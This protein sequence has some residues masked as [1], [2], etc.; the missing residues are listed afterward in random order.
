MSSDKISIEQENPQIV[1]SD[2]NQKIPRVPSTNSVRKSLDSRAS[3]ES[4]DISKSSRINSNHVVASGLEEPQPIKASNS[5]SQNSLLKNLSTNI[6]SSMSVKKSFSA[7]SL[8]AVEPSNINSVKDLSSCNDNSPLA[9]S[10]QIEISPRPKIDQAFLPSSLSM[11]QEKNPVEI[12]NKSQELKPSSYSNLVNLKSDL[13]NTTITASNITEAGKLNN[14]QGANTDASR[15]SDLEKA[16]EEP[17]KLNIKEMQK[18]LHESQSST[19]VDKIKIESNGNVKT[20]QNKILLPGA[21]PTDRPKTQFD[22]NDEV[23][24]KRANSS[25]GEDSSKF[26]GQLNTK[27][28]ISQGQPGTPTAI[29]VDLPDITVTT[30]KKSKGFLGMGKKIIAADPLDVVLEDE[31]GKIVQ[32]PETFHKYLET[33]DNF[34]YESIAS[35]GVDFEGSVYK[36]TRGLADGR[37]LK[38]LKWNSYFVQVS[39]GFMFF[40]SEQPTKKKPAKS[41]GILDIRGGSVQRKNTKKGNEVITIYNDFGFQ[42]YLAAEKI[43]R[44]DALFGSLEKNVTSYSDTAAP[45]DLL[46]YFPKK[47]VKKGPAGA[48]FSVFAAMKEKEEEEKRIEDERKKKEEEERESSANSTVKTKRGAK[49]P[50]R[51]SSEFIAEIEK[52]PVVFGVPLDQ[53]TFKKQ[54]KIPLIVEKCFQIVEDRGKDV[55][56]IYRLS[57]NSDEIKKIRQLIEDNP[58]TFPESSNPLLS[59]VNNITGLFKLF[60]RQLPNPLI[61]Y[62]DYNKFIEILSTFVL[63]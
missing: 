30:E 36:I 35:W 53:L 37:Q 22:P 55:V 44:F 26:V 19:V 51:S 1:I 18:K 49:L 5:Q 45:P 13:V 10:P 52:D 3:H 33:L 7:R 46:I 25:S 4:L 31:E 27:L 39:Q 17:K 16:P 15:K 20:M 57:G 61:P 29:T 48:Q 59:D 43:D 34:K 12:I 11:S 56:G 60:L 6:D 21:I 58:D 41:L 47:E 24:Q 54:R 42:I 14:I 50:T 28:V 62:S 63:I 32:E 40:L 8:E 9:N 23:L 38:A 2:E